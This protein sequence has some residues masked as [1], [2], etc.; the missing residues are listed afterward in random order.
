MAEAASGHDP[1][2]AGCD[3]RVATRELLLKWTQLGP[4]SSYTER[5]RGAAAEADVIGEQ[6]LR[7]T[8]S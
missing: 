8:G 6:Q 5:N 1:G 7:L 2:A 4:N 3:L